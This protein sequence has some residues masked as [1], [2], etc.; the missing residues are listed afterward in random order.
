MTLLQQC[1]SL[2]VL[3]K[4]IPTN[5]ERILTTFSAKTQCKTTICLMNKHLKKYTLLY[6][7]MTQY[8]YMCKICEVFFIHKPCP[9]SCGRGAW[10]HVATLPTENLKKH[11]SRQ[12]E[13]SAHV[14]AALMKTKARIKDALSKS[15]KKTTEEK[16]RSNELYIGKLIKAAHFLAAN[17]LAV[18]G[19][20]PKLVSFLQIILKSQL[21]SSP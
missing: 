15:N 7:S 3:L 18:T 16:K 1:Q 14:N 6:Y 13:S 10:S 8:G 9:S 4:R 12:D 2:F 11:F 19:L 21:L 20:Y 17:N 5:L